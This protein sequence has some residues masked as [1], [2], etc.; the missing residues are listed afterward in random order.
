M[1]LKFPLITRNQC[2]AQASRRAENRN[3]R[4][5]QAAEACALFP[6]MFRK[7]IPNAAILPVLFVALSG[8]GEERNAL[9]PAAT[10]QC[11]A[12]YAQ[13]QV[14][15]GFLREGCG[16][17]ENRAGTVATPSA[18]LTC[19]VNAGTLVSFYYAG[20]TLEHQIVPVG[21]PAFQP[22]AL[23]SPE[24]LESI[25]VH[26]VRFSTPGTYNFSDAMNSAL[27]GRIIVQ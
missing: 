18:T 22:S 10:G 8:C 15:D 4:A 14:E 24:R 11:P 2:G 7:I 9:P 5:G 21:T 23:F 25:R 12:G 16:C 13:V 17:Q 19:T 1:F 26:S 27:K 3:F 6:L 20:S